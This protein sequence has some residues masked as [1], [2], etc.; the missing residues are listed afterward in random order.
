MKFDLK[1]SEDLQQY[2]GSMN[3]MENRVRHIQEGQSSSLLWFLEHPSLFTQGA[4]GDGSIPSGFPVI[5]SS[6][7]GKVTYH[8]PGQR[9]IYVMLQLQGCMKDVRLYI[10]FL[11]EWIIQTLFHFNIVGKRCAGRVGVWVDTPEG[12][13]KIAAVGVRIQKWVTSHGLSLNINPD[14]TLYEGITPCGLSEFGVTSL[15][16]LGVKTTLK[17][18]DSIFLEMLPLVFQK[19]MKGPFD[20]YCKN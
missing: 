13:K 15:E 11:E 3:F 4:G 5:E 9:V 12:E 16:D 6:R 17:Q 7:G 18:V 14:L 10:Y 19:V 2:T 8:G 20:G 1:I